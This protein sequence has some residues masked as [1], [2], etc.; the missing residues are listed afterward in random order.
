LAYKVVF[1]KKALRDLQKI[2]HAG[3]TR[4]VKE[5]TEILVKNPYQAPPRFESFTGDLRGF[6]LA[7]L[8]FNTDVFIR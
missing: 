2:K 8:I 1:S 7:V 5:I 6:F 4:Q 3:L